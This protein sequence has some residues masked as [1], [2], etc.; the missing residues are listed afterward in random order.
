MLRLGSRF[1]PR[2]W[3]D[4]STCSNT[5]DDLIQFGI[6]HVVAIDDLISDVRDFAHN[7]SPG[8]PYNSSFLGRL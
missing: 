1:E 8:V 6:R 4:I 5:N 7:P 3:Y 2:W